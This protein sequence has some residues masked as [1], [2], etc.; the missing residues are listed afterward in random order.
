MIKLSDFFIE[1]KKHGTHDQQSHAGGRRGS[2]A[3]PVTYDSAKKK[4]ILKELD[5]IQ[6]RQRKLRDEHEVDGYVGYYNY[7]EVLPPA[8]QKQWLKNEKEWEDKRQEIVEMDQ[9]YF[10]SAIEM[11]SGNSADGEDMGFSDPKFRDIRDEYVV[12]DEKTLQ[13]NAGLRRT[14][15]V[16]TKVQR[17]DSMVAEGEIINPTKVHRAAILSSDQ[18]KTLQPGTS[19]VD[20]GFQSVGIEVSDATMY[21]DSRARDIAGE[22]VLFDYTLQPG[23]NAVNV[24]YGEIVVQRGAKVTVT[25]LGKSG[26][27]TVVRA[28]VSKP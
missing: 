9:E 19:F 1:V 24:G 4:A 25:G 15:R 14:G 17:F 12:P 23:L 8:A 3:G 2:S 10:D 28:E 11:K 26:D 7:Q 18:V 22:K 6:D 20:R 13:T 5:A 16:T 21:G 27:Y